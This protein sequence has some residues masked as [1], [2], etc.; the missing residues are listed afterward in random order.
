MRKTG[1][2][3]IAAATLL[4]I[5]VT[6]AAQRSIIV[7][8]GAKPSMLFSPAVEANGLIFTSGQLALDPTSGKVEGDI[9]A[10]TRQAMKNLQS[11]L[12]AGGSSLDNL[13]KINIYLKNIDDYAK[14]NQVYVTFFN[15]APPAR[16]ALQVGKI[17]MDALIEIEG[18]AVKP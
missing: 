14:M 2:M 18:I 9:E 13:V 7:P 5:N 10:Q 1:L 6:Q 11:V 3:L 8:D 17:P 12:E 16:T 15:G 4:S